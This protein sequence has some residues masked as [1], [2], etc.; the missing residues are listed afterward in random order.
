M[1]PG[2]KPGEWE[3]IRIETRPKVKAAE[4][5]NPAHTNGVSNAEGA[6]V[7]GES[8]TADAPAP[9]SAD[10]EMS[11]APAAESHTAAQPV[12]GTD[13][14]PEAEIEQPTATQEDEVE[15]ED[16]PYS[17]EGAVYPIVEGRVENWPCFFAL[18]SHIWKTMGPHF[19]SPLIVISQP[20]WTARDKEMITQYFFQDHRIPAF[21]MMDSALAAC[22]AYGIPSG[23]VIDVGL[24][25]CD[26]SA[27]TD[28]TVN[29]AG[30]GVALSGCGGRTMT[31]RLQEALTQK[32]ISCDEPM[33]E[34]LKRSAVCE[35]LSPGVALP[36]G[37]PA[38]PVAVAATATNGEVPNPAAAAST[39]AVDSGADA[40]DAEGAQPGEAPRGPGNGTVVGEEGDNE[41]D[42]EGVLDVAAIVAQSNAAE[43]LAKREAEKAAKAAAKKGATAEALRPVRLRNAEREKATFTYDELLPYGTAGPDGSRKRKREIE[44][45]TERFMAAT[46]AEGHT[47]G[48]FDT[49]C[50][51][52]HATVLGVPDVTLRSG[53]WENVILLGNGSRVRGMLPSLFICIDRC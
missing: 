7:N 20:C 18:L 44:I 10:V 2:L 46:P 6:V 23:L 19:V 51:A 29:E 34:A 9:A 31:K 36:T 25:K 21:C 3:P 15:Y 16:D 4:E 35:I 33:A 50:A 27:V 13:V 41:D 30:R 12:N 40:K 26:V 8:T 42:N 53:L 47:E 28:F 43:V 11:E 14:A 39:G 49:I 17:E 1:F 38:A 5:H 24:D 45:G 37:K 48:I 22:Y 32:G 52:A